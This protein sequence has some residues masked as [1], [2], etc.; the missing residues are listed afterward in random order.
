MDSVKNVFW[1]SWA[2]LKSQAKD[3]ME[4]CAPRRINRATKLVEHIMARHT[5]KK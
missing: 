2:V 5:K 4:E 1:K 3:V